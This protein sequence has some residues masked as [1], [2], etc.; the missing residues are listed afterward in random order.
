VA[1][2]LITEALQALAA[3]TPEAATEI[4]RIKLMLVDFESRSRNDYYASESVAKFLAESRL[5]AVEAQRDALMVQ[6]DQ[7]SNQ[8]L[9]YKS[10]ARRSFGE[11]ITDA[12]T[13]LMNRKG[14]DL[15]VGQLESS[16]GSTSD[17]AVIY[18]DLND[19]RI[20]NNT[21]GHAAGDALIK[22][23]AFALAQ[24]TRRGDFSARIGG[25]EFVLLAS[26]CDPANLDLVIN[27]IKESFVACGVK[28]SIGACARSTAGTLPNACVE[29]DRQMYIAKAKSKQ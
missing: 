6:L 21:L 18:V 27:R 11:S 7:T 8:L 20:T 3:N 2:Q 15:V 5:R 9:E 24:N 16:L 14:W 4:E 12:L 22:K 25:D 29:A 17:A 13:G 26:G 19:L 1:L 23:A 10:E 28:A